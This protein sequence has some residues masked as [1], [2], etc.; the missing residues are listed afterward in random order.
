M[1]PHQPLVVLEAMKMEHIV[2]APHAGIVTDLCV[3]VGQQVRAGVQLL[4][5]GSAEQTGGE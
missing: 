1:T 4:I 3:E 5:L 2:E